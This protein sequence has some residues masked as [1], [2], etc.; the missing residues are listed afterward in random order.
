MT[1]SCP[2]LVHNMRTDTRLNEGAQELKDGS[3]RRSISREGPTQEN[4]VITP[5]WSKYCFGVDERT[6][7]TCLSGIFEEKRKH[8]Q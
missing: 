1:S 5:D 6:A 4:Q 8:H 7:R 2:I 3:C